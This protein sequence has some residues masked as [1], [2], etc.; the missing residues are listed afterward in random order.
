[1]KYKEELIASETIYKGKIFDVKVDDVKLPDGNFAKREIVDHWGA[2]TIIAI[3]I[4]KKI[5]L[6]RQYRH[7]VNKELYELPA[8]KL[9]LDLDELS[10]AK[11]ELKEETGYEA[12]KWEKIYECWTTPGFSNERM[13]F[14]T[15]FNLKKV[16]QQLEADEFLDVIE[17]S[18][19]E[20]LEM[21][22][23]GQI[24]DAKTSLGI[25]FIFINN[26][27]VS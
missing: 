9:D 21:I 3:T 24:E 5:L 16:K 14:F 19:I 23:K 6:V 27:V 15:A 18:I 10:T 8:G 2:V 25:L 1:M 7:A 20:A 11:Q 22:K 17:V 13:H 12:E 26:I 4:D